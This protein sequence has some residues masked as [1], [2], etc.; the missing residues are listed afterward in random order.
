MNANIGPGEIL[1]ILIV[2]LLVVGPEKLPKFARALGKAIAG[3][4]SYMNDV[5]EDLKDATDLREVTDSLSDMQK[6]MQKTFKGVIDGA[7]VDK[8]LKKAVKDVNKP[9]SKKVSEPISEKK[10]VQS[11]AGTNDTAAEEE[12]KEEEKKEEAVP[13]KACVTDSEL[14]AEK[15][16]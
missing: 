10:K 11:T 2:A 8:D 13:D 5:T 9:A 3:F 7:D 16:E 15:S 1:V 12:K 6:D 4:K 14:V